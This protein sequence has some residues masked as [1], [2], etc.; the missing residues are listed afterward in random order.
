MLFRSLVCTIATT[1]Q[2][3]YSHVFGIE[4]HDRTDIYNRLIGHHLVQGFN[5]EATID[6]YTPVPTARRMP[7]A[8][9]CDTRLFRPRGMEAKELMS[10][11]EQISNNKCVAHRISTGAA[12]TYDC[13]INYYKLR[14]SSCTR[15]LGIYMDN[16]LKFAQHISKITHIG[17][18]RAALIL[19]CFLTRDPQV[20]LKSYCTNA[21]PILEYC[22][23]VWSLHH[24]GLN[25]KLENVQRR[26]TKRVNGL[27]CLSYMKIVLFI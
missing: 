13:K 10:S 21:R 8:S 27:S 9:T 17:H 7:Y 18:S 25:D 16:D 15:D 22:T 24:T 12:S 20:L 19:K 14:W 2:R 26:F 5:K 3:L 6:F 23:P 4:Q 11:L 1:F